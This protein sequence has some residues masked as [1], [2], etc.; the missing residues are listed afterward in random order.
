M[1]EHS[2]E[3]WYMDS[4]PNGATIRHADGGFVFR[5]GSKENQRRIVA[6]VN[7]CK[8]IPTEVLCDIALMDTLASCDA[9]IAAVQFFKDQSHD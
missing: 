6:C 5:T 8:G 2:P 7:A 9:L 1:T 4:D 3:P